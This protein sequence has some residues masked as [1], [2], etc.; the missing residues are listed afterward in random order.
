M[1]TETGE[2]VEKTMTLGEHINELRLRVFLCIGAVLFCTIASYFFVPDVFLP[3]LRAPFDSLRGDAASNPF[4]IQTPILKMLTENIDTAKTKDLQLYFTGVSQPLV[5]RLKMALIIGIILAMPVLLHQIWSFVSLGLYPN[6]RRKVLLYGPASL[7]LFLLGAAIAYFLIL[8]VSVAFLL[9]EG[10]N[11]GM[12]S[13]IT[14]DDYTSFV[15]LMMV[16]LGIV[17]QMPLVAM[18]LSAIGVISDKTLSHYRGISVVLIFIAAAIITPSADP[19]SQC[20][21][22]IPMIGLY[23]V[24]IILAKISGKRNEIEYPD[25]D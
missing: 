25:I 7:L 22:A 4:V 2:L 13:I 15:L 10:Y 12:Q 23:E 18:F 20:A 5:F 9:N 16:A 14:I 19:F 1:E 11:M 21:V 24:S 3:I 6:E 17:F 8:P